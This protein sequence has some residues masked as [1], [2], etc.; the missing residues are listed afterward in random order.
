M[1]QR[2]SYEEYER[3]RLG[4]PRSPW[5]GVAYTIRRSFSAASFAGF[6]RYWNPLFSYYLYYGCY[7]PLSRFLPRPVAVLLTFAVSGAVHDVAGSL[8]TWDLFIL[9]TPVFGFFG[10]VVVAEEGV[11][12][13]LAGVPVWSR[14]FIHTLVIA[15]TV[16]V[17]VLLRSGIP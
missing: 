17:G 1:K 13:S 3:R 16:A 5:G 8:A 15:G 6:W 14:V 12:L 11:G 7:R 10:L 9:F 4:N 2:I